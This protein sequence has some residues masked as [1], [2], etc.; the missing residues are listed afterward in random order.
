MLKIKADPIR[1]LLVI[2]AEGFLTDEELKTGTDLCIVE[3]KKLKE[4]FTVINDIAKMKPASPAG[5]AE[6]KRAQ[7]YAINHGVSRFIRVT[8]NPI[9]KIQ[10]IRTS[11]ELGYEALEVSTIKE[12]YELIK[13]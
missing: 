11:E 4:G 8:K 1:N 12:A 13:G 9:S 2:Q 6:I 3:A 10:F 7:I 5:V